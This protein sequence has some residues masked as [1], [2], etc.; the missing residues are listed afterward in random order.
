MLGKVSMSGKLMVISGFALAGLFLFGM[1]SFST[2][3]KVKVNGPIYRQIVENK[4]LVADVLPPP[5]YITELYLNTL[6]MLHADSPSERTALQNKATVMMT[7]YQTRHTFWEQTLEDGPL[8][9]ALV[10]KADGHAEAFF[11]ARRT[12]FLPALE[13]GDHVEAE[14][15]Y[16]QELTPLFNRHLDAIQEVVSLAN[17]RTSSV[18]VQTAAVLSHERG[19]MLGLCLTTGFSLMLISWKVGGSIITP[20]Q[21][22][23]EVLEAVEKGDYGQTLH[24]QQEDE[25]GRMAQALN[26]VLRGING[27]VQHLLSNLQLAAKG[28]LRQDVQLT[29][30]DPLSRMGHHLQQ[31][32]LSLRASIGEIAHNAH[33]LASASDELKGLGQQMEKGAVDSSTRAQGVAN[34]SVRVNEVVNQVAGATEELSASIREIAYTASSANRVVDQAVSASTRSTEAITRLQRRNEEIGSV[35]STIRSLAR[36]T[37]LLALNAGIEAARAGSMGRSFLVVANEVKELSRSTTVA[38]E[39][40]AIKLGSMQ[41]D[42]EETVT[43]VSEVVKLIGQISTHQ[44]HITESVSQQSLAVNEIAQQLGTAALECEDIRASLSG[45]RDN[46]QSTNRQAREMALASEQLS[47]M[48][49]ALSGLVQRFRVQ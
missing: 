1:W 5:L 4:D 17:T 42:V 29:G 22:T 36:Q 40:I 10:Q 19:F 32:T 9:D 6:L 35:V 37:N 33:A 13:R 43:T 38:A 25:V 31:L 41:A 11:E 8:R 15:I 44:Q 34:S 2:L 49:Q 3:E 39:G 7:D 24:I 47:Q 12:R 48:S 21:R 28:D 16:E 26:A 18:E 45:F 46:L 23:M 20:L 30:S 14:R 27:R